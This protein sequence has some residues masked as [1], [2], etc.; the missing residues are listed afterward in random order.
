MDA[1]IAHNRLLLTN[2]DLKELFGLTNVEL[3]LVNIKNNPTNLDI[4]DSVFDKLNKYNS[5][6]SKETFDLHLETLRLG[7]L[8]KRRLH[9]ENKNRIEN[10]KKLYIKELTDIVKQNLSKIWFR[11]VNTKYTIH[12]GATNSGKTYNA[13]KRLME[14]NGGVYLAPLR[15]LAFEVYEKIISNDVNC[16]LITGEEKIQNN[17]AISSRTIEMMDYTKSYDCI[18]VDEAFMISDPIRGKQW[19]KTIMESNSNEIH[20]VSSLESVDLI[21][22]LLSVAK[23][24]YEIIKYER[25]VPLEVSNSLYNFNAVLKKTVFVTFSRVSVLYEKQRLELMG[26]KVSVLYGNLPPEVKRDQMNKFISGEHNVCV[27]TDVIG[28]GL[29]LP[30]DHICFLKVEKYDGEKNRQLTR[31]EAKQIAGRAGRFGLSEKGTVWTANANHNRAITKLLSDHIVNI[32]NAYCPIDYDTLVQLPPTSLYDK[33]MYYETLSLIPEELSQI[34]KTENISIYKER[35]NLDSKLHKMPLET[36]WKLINLPIKNNNMPIWKKM[37]DCVSKNAKLALP[38]YNSSYTINTDMS[39]KYVEDKVA[40][41]ELVLYFANVGIFKE[42]VSDINIAE[43][44]TIRY[45]YA[46][47]ITSYLLVQKTTKS[48]TFGKSK[49]YY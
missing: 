2:K 11:N 5:F 43:L 23:R 16:D 33:L 20:I 38:N 28:M 35:W 49:K 17:A 34:V 45:S 12:V 42:H 40:E 6:D 31:T 24:E 18:V 15:L 3:H 37:I 10:E 32:E 36:T 47:S 25:K 14:C 8:E 48:K 1:S 4:T 27:S 13:I 39:L 9:E 26:N 19:F 44:S 22:K 30:C 7:I 46:D 29:N 41:I 21:T